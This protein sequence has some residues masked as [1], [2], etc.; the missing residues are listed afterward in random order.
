MV[1][2]L[3]LSKSYAYVSQVHSVHIENQ[4]NFYSNVL[5]G[6]HVLNIGNLDGLVYNVIIKI[7][8]L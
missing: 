3:S 5:K 2:V 6:L 8:Y 7:H 4:L 1:C